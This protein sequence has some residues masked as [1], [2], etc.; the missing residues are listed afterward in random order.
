MILEYLREMS[1][2]YAFENS[3]ENFIT[4]SSISIKQA[5]VNNVID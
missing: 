1:L 2:F 4:F 3:V 5:M